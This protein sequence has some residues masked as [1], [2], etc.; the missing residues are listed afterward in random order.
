M[1]VGFSLGEVMA[2]WAAG[3]RWSIRSQRCLAMV[4]V[5]H[6]NRR[7]S[8]MLHV[9][10]TSQHHHLMGRLRVLFTGEQQQEGIWLLRWQG[11][12]RRQPCKRRGGASS[13][14]SPVC[15]T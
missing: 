15:C 13:S 8:E 5:G 7:A 1:A 4:R 3:L 9:H 10:T 2:W 11:S 14:A 6:R 12:S